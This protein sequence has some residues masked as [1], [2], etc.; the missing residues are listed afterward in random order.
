MFIYKFIIQMWPNIVFFFFKQYLLWE[1]IYIE[2]F[3][4]NI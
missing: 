3:T 1:F 4:R 2:L